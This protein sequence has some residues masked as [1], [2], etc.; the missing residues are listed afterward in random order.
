[1]NTRQGHR[2]GAAL[3]WSLIEVLIA[4]AIVAILAAIAFPSYVDAVHRGW[5]AEARSALLAQ[6][7]QQERHFTVDGRYRRYEGDSAESGQGGKYLVRSEH[8]DGQRS[9]DDCLRL[10]ARLKPGFSDP[11]VGNLWLDSTGGRGCD[12][13]Q[14]ARCWQ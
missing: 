7:Q 12:G 8:C 11:P 2:A 10:S 9:L 6:M 3:G 13:A 1:M 14:R 4:L 5:R